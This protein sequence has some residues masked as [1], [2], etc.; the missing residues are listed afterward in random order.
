MTAGDLKQKDSKLAGDINPNDAQYRIQ[1]QL[2]IL[3]SQFKMNTLQQNLGKT[4][5]HMQ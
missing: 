4:K 3:E 5:Q 1:Q 2:A